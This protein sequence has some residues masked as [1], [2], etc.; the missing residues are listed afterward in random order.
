MLQFWWERLWRVGKCDSVLIFGIRSGNLAPFMQFFQDSDHFIGVVVNIL[1]CFSMELF[2]VAVRT[3]TAA[4]VLF[5]ILNNDSP[6]GVSDRSSSKL[7]QRVVYNELPP[8]DQNFSS[9]TT[10]NLATKENSPTAITNEQSTD[11]ISFQADT[12]TVGLGGVREIR[13]KA[14]NT[15][16]LGNGDQQ[17][18]CSTS[19]KVVPSRNKTTNGSA[20]RVD[21]TSKAITGQIIQT[22][23]ATLPSHQSSPS[24]NSAAPPVPTST[25]NMSTGH[26]VSARSTKEIKL[27]TSSHQPPPATASNETVRA[28]HF[29]TTQMAPAPSV[30][31]FSD[32]RVRSENSSSGLTNGFATSSQSSRDANGPQMTNNK[33]AGESRRGPFP[34]VPSPTKEALSHVRRYGPNGGA[35]N[36]QGPNPQFA[37]SYHGLYAGGQ[38][39]F[40]RNPPPFWD[41][42]PSGCAPNMRG[43]STHA[44]EK[45]GSFWAT[46]STTTTLSPPNVQLD[47]SHS[48][49]VKNS[50]SWIA[51][52]RG[53]CRFVL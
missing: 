43:L 41:S 2:L 40:T 52:I 45:R 7:P 17:K 39:A 44:G 15:V 10:S 23:T 12:N 16:N 32:Q 36:P 1:H 35:I 14:G 19:L 4:S 9:S 21:G 46:G 27:I 3:T 49:T 20:P 30:T 47:L 26:G 6:E 48:N 24:G 50:V 25:K 33:V 37:L 29:S 28:V 18:F 8:A 31:S 53:P 51:K 22:T 42:G 34:T 13:A 11:R 5:Q 38:G